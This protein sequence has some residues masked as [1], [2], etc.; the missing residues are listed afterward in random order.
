MILVRTVIPYYYDEEKSLIV[1]QGKLRQMLKFWH[2]S[3]KNVT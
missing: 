3:R 2:F 1:A